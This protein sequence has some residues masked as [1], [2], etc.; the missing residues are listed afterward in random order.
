MSTLTELASQL[1]AIDSVN[2]DLVSGAA[3][4]AEIARFVAAWLERAGLRVS[5]IG[6]NPSRPSVVAVAP[7]TGGGNSLL[8]NA[9]LDT[10]GA[11]GMTEPFTPRLANGRLRGR[12]ALDMKASLAA[13]M[14]TGAAVAA[15]PNRGDLIITAVADE[16]FASIGIQEVVATTRADAA[17]VTEP[18]SLELSIAHKGFA[19][20]E[21]VAHGFAAHGSLPA[22]G[23]D[24]IAALG[25][26]L[27]GIAQLECDLARQTG[28]PLLGPG[29]IHASLIHGGTELST[30]PD[31]CLLT[32][33]R[34]MIPGETVRQIEIDVER[35]LMDARRLVPR[36]RITA[37]TT[38]VR[39]PF[40][41]A[42]DHPFVRLASE[43]LERVSGRPTVVSGSGGWMDSAFLAAVGIPTVIVGPGG[44]GLHGDDEWVDIA[45]SE[46]LVTFLHEL[47]QSFCN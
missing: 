12:G 29:S 31:H 20:I 6:A 47:A 3:G 25:P 27:T 38:L 23:I 43:T 33:E 14:L 13:I 32:I 42:A 21:V 34:R 5:V 36:A 35:L 26:V 46:L 4:E 1:I 44:E 39:E 45:S 19:W 41:I 40:A 28:H 24:A 10:V 15:R 11:G 9:H 2:P 17:V 37:R 8:L 18:T 7:G 30:Y 16:E 22:V